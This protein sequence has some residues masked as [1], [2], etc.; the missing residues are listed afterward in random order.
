MKLEGDRTIFHKMAFWLGT[1]CIVTGVS[2][3]LP[4]FIGARTMRYQLAGMPMSHLMLAG[5]ALI[6]TGLV[7]TMYGLFPVRTRKAP[8]ASADYQLHTMDNVR[9]GWAHWK[10]VTV[11]GAALVV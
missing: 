3:H 4:D 7:A 1:I 8:D 9:L 6:V 5:M 10:L 2:F 11:L